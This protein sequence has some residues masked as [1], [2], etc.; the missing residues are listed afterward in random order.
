[1]EN[2]AEFFANST[3]DESALSNDAQPSCSRP[4]ED[5]SKNKISHLVIPGGGIAGFTYYGAL[6]E[7]A[8]Q[9][10]WSIDNIQTIYGTSV[11]SI[12]A[13]ILALKYDWETIDDYLIKRPWQNVFKFDM[14]SLIGSIKKRGIFD[15][16]I[17]EDVF[18]PLFSGKDIPIHVTMREFFEITKIEIH[19]ITVDANSFELIDISYKTHPDWRVVDAVYASSSLPII[20]APFIRDDKFYCDGGLVLNYPVSK[21]IE[22]GANPNEILGFCRQIIKND[23]PEITNDSTLLDYLLTIFNK[24]FQ[25]IIWLRAIYSISVEYIVPSVPMSIASIYNTTVS[26]EERIRLIDLGKK[27]VGDPLI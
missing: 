23:A 21:C 16:K 19:I 1:M 3:S 26:M 18:Q 27:I 5:I 2:I 25:K 20:F 9:G 8:I 14:Y 4:L 13:V 10:V 15:I 17:M 24:S 12:I 22:N 7:S 6:R 11:G